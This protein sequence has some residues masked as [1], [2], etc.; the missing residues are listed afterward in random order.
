MISFSPFSKASDYAEHNTLENPRF[1]K[2][3][4]LLGII[5]DSE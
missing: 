2:H 3:P 5:R 1:A 4:E